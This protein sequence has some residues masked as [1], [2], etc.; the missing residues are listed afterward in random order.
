[1][2]SCIRTRRHEGGYKRR[3]RRGLIN[4]EVQR[5][6]RGL[7]RLSSL[8]GIILGLT[9]TRT[10]YL[11]SA[12][13]VGAVCAVSLAFTAPCFGPKCPLSALKIN[14]IAETGNGESR[15]KSHYP[16]FAA[17]GEKTRA[18]FEKRFFFLIKV[19]LEHLIIQL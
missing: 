18:M 6:I 12:V 10:S 7:S 13:V 1:M 5:T 3:S 19:S 11:L 17:A 4:Q 2:K 16:K 8:R 9:P 15:S 14:A